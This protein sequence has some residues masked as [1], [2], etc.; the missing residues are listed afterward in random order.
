M[1]WMVVFFGLVSFVFATELTIATE[2]LVPYNYE[3]DGKV[4][5]ISVE[6]V[7][8]IQKKVGN[9]DKIELQSWNKAY[10]RTLSEPN[11][12]LFSTYRTK[13]R[14]DLFKWVGPISASN[15]N[16]FK[17]S[18]NPLEI[19]TLDDAK[20]V[21]FIAAGPKTNIDYIVLSKLG[22]E[23]LSNLDTQSN[24]IALIIN[25]RADLGASN[26]LTAFFSVKR[27]GYPVDIITDT[28][29]TVLE[30]GLYIAV[31]KGTDDAIVAK[32]QKALDELRDSGEMKKI[33]DAALKEA[34][35]DFGIEKN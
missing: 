12:M 10:Q 2:D 6:I 19:K 27:D 14:E 35:S 18:D 5:G 4:K 9:S 28:G 33:A 17:R 8:A 26:P 11:N 24:T 20:K 23:N 22:F 15:V 25:K 3:K 21:K 30:A 13:E 1:R 32:W 7:K 29:V 16:L 34:Y 31:S